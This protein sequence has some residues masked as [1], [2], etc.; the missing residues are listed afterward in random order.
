MFFLLLACLLAAL[1]RCWFVGQVMLK[2]NIVN[3]TRSIVLV[4]LVIVCSPMTIYHKFVQYLFI[5]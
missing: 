3:V 2:Q 5:R 4:I 1:L